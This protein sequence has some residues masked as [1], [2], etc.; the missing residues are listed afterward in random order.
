MEKLKFAKLY[1][2]KLEVDTKQRVRLI[3]DLALVKKKSY[4]DTDIYLVSNIHIT[5][6]IKKI[7][8]RKKYYQ[9]RYDGQIFDITG[10]LLDDST[11][12]KIKERKIKRKLHRTK[13][14]Y[15]CSIFDLECAFDYIEEAEGRIFFEVYSPK[16]EKVVIAKSLLE[17]LGYENFITESYDRIF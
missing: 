10:A 5:E 14:V 12:K 7:G 8:A 4:S 17:K 11:A 13:D 1:E 2:V 3:K 6:K 9:I 16:R 15:M